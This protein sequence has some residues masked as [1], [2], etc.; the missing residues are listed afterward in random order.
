M[1]SCISTR[2]TINIVDPNFCF[3]R[4]ITS[5]GIKRSAVVNGSTIA[6]GDRCDHDPLP[7]VVYIFPDEYKVQVQVTRKLHNHCWVYEFYSPHPP[8]VLRENT[9]VDIHVITKTTT[10]LKYRYNLHL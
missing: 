2:Q 4:N 1:G 6:Y 9:D 7:E 3:F 10:K 8:M 5:E